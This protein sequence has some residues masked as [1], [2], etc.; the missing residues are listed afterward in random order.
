MPD[1]SNILPEGLSGFFAAFAQFSWVI[2]LALIVHVLRTGRPYWWIFILLFAPGL[3][4]LAYLFIE[5]LP[6]FRSPEGFIQS[7]T[8]RSWKISR[9]RKTLEE[10][11]TVAN[12]I[13]LAETLFEA[14]QVQEAHDLAVECL[15]GVFKTDPRTLVD[16]ARFKLALNQHAQALALLETVDTTADRRLAVQVDVLTGDA[17]LGLKRY[18]EAEAA[19]QKVNGRYIGEAPRAGLALVYENTRRKPE[20]LALWKDIRA[21]FRKANPVWRRTERKWYKLATAKLKSAPAAR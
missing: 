3:G 5:L 17:F 8:P 14:G 13:Q 12:R 11:E 20:A 4:G 7:I 16:A 18:A 1:P 15:S 2:Q 21:K 6:G 19:Y 10:T 9:Q